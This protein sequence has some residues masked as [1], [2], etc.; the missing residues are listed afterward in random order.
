M[1]V[2]ARVAQEIGVKLGAE[3][4]KMF[5]MCC[6]YHNVYVSVHLAFH[7][8]ATALGLRTVLPKKQL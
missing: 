2:A 5:C 7:R 4:R 6:V 3:V 8:L 1:S